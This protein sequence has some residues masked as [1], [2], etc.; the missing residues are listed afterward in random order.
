MCSTG[1]FRNDSGKL[2]LCYV[3]KRKY[4]YKTASGR[5][6]FDCLVLISAEVFLYWFCRWYS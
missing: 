1:V 3:R 2:N 5:H 6:R 4:E